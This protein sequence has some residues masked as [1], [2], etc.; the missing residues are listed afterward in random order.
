MNLSHKSFGGI[1]VANRT[2]KLL[3]KLMG[4]LK[5]KGVF[6]LSVARHDPLPPKGELDLVLRLSARPVGVARLAAGLPA[7]PELLN[8]PVTPFAHDS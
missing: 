2:S 8:R 7:L 5:E 1:L 6:S 3:N 4:A